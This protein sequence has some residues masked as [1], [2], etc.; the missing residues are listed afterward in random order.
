MR[1]IT[2]AVRAAERTR[3]RDPGILETLLGAH[4]EAWQMDRAEEIA[5]VAIRLASKA[6]VEN[7]SRTIRDRLGYY[8]RPK[9]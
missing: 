1:A 4:A 6:G 9:P 5:Q 3:N 7:C 2:V 8:K